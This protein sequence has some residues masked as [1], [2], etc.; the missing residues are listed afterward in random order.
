MLIIIGLGNPGKEYENTF[1]NI[2][3][4]FVDSFA[5]DFD[6]EFSLKKSINAL[7]AEKK[8][9]TSEIFDKYGI[10]KQG[11]LEKVVLVKPQTYMNLSGVAVSSLIKKYGAK[12]EE[13]V[14]VLDDIDLPIGKFRIRESGSA[15]THNGLRNIVSMLGSGDFKRIRIGI[16]SPHNTDLATYVLSKISNAQNEEIEKCI[17]ASKKEFFNNV[18]F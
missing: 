12:L 10:K 5:R 3:F 16:N 4:K 1:H 9:D 13:I 8:F 17:E 14:V 11:K 6:F 7:V 18:K 2:G 15:G